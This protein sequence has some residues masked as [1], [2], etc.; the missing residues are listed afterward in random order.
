[1]SRKY[2]SLFLAVVLSLSMAVPVFASN[3]FLDADADNLCINVEHM[4]SYI[5]DSAID[6]E[7]WGYKTE[8][9]DS[10]YIG[11]PI[12]T[13]EYLNTGALQEN[14]FVYYPVFSENGLPFLI[15]EENDGAI[16]LTQDFCDL[17]SDFYDEDIAIIYDSDETYIVCA[18]FSKTK[19]AHRAQTVIGLRGNLSDI[20]QLS[21]N[22]Q[23][24]WTALAKNRKIPSFD[25]TAQPA[26]D[27]LHPPI[28]LTVPKVL[29]NY[30][31]LC[32]AACLSS[33]G[34][35]YTGVVHSPEYLAKIYFNS[36]DEDV[37]NDTPSFYEDMEFFKAQYGISYPRDKV[38]AANSNLIYEN[39]SNKYPVFGLFRFRD[40]PSNSHLVVISGMNPAYG[41]MNIMDPGSGYRYITKSNGEYSYTNSHGYEVFLYGQATKI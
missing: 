40:N 2:L 21:T 18:D 4:L 12:H 7:N 27:P 14:D 3:S 31:K 32:W 19:V 24:E 11:L 35:Y 10:L 22:S 33:V 25:Q 28:N 34:E 6:A 17:L 30:S 1:M 5:Y 16:Q 23:I 20:P 37:F 13:Y 38:V 15:L 41:T 36:T 8:D 29:Q 9:F 39:L 26:Y